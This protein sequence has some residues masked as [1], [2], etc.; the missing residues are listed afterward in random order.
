MREEKYKNPQEF[1]NSVMKAANDEIE[2]MSLMYNEAIES[3]LKDF[4]PYF[5]KNSVYNAIDKLFKDKELE[6]NSFT[7]PEN[8]PKGKVQALAKEYFGKVLVNTDDEI[9]EIQG[10]WYSDIK[11]RVK[12]IDIGEFKYASPIEIPIFKIIEEAS[13]SSVEEKDKAR[14]GV[15]GWV[16]DRLSFIFGTEKVAIFSNKK[17]VD[18][19]KSDLKKEFSNMEMKTRDDLSKKLD[20]IVTN[21]KA[22]KDQEINKRKE[23]LKEISDDNDQLKIDIESTKKHINE[24]EGYLGKLKTISGEL[25]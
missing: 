1:N 7:I 5:N 9:K 4:K 25:K 17:F 12:D 15:F 14:D 22:Y 24:L 8:E 18:K 3:V 20:S 6:L 13:E 23:A 21:I 10:K 19:T 2:R 11:E 16:K